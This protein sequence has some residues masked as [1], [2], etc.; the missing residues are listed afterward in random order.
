MNGSDRRDAQMKHGVRRGLLRNKRAPGGG[1]HE[2]RR[3]QPNASGGGG[4][5][6]VT[7]TATE[8]LE[9]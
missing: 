2:W 9:R 8:I 4:G 6:G 3:R 1:W 5:G 7:R